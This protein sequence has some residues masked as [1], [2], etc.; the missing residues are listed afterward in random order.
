MYKSFL[1]ETRKLEQIWKRSEKNRAILEANNNF[2]PIDVRHIIYHSQKPFI[3][4]NVLER[5]TSIWY[6]NIPIHNANE[7]IIENIYPVATFVFRDQG[8]PTAEVPI[9]DGKF[10]W[11]W[12]KITETSFILRFAVDSNL[13]TS[14]PWDLNLDLIIYNRQVFDNIQKSVI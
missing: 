5:E 14:E 13:D 10:Y 12:H 9:I 1:T 7:Q 6:G 8:I 2:K 11:W 4:F 3:K